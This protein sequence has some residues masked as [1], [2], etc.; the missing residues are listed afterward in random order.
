MKKKKH[1]FHIKKAERLEIAI[2]LNRGYSIRDIAKAIG[3][4]KSSVAEEI[5]NRSTKGKYDPRQANIKARLKRKYSKYQGMKIREDEELEQYVIEKLKLD[6]SP[7]E[8]AGRIKNIDGHIKYSSHQAIYQ[9]LDSIFGQRYVKYLRK[10]GKRKKRGRKGKLEKLQDRVFIENRPKIIDEKQR[11]GDFEGDFIVSGRDGTGALLVLYERKS[12]HVIIK[13]IMSRKADEVNKII[14]ELTGVFV[15]F[16]SLTL[17]NDVSFKK[18]AALSELLG[19][20]IYFCHPYHSWEKGGVENIN[21]LIR[22]YIPKKTDISK[23]SDE[24]IR[25]VENRLNNRPRKSL[26]YKTPLEVMKENG[27]FK[28]ENQFDMIINI[29]KK[30]QAVRLEG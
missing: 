5:K 17:D 11:F 10:K 26:G 27:Q 3:K 13:K 20:P 15:S 25:S 12:R 14:H 22:Y 24:F 19:A 1:Y 7:E 8:I 16:N 9:Y 18:H 23:L 2:L 30:S 4:G 28:K 6:W 21:G 29:N